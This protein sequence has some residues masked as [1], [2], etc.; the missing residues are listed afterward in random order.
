MT[1]QGTPK[2]V[3]ATVLLAGSMVGAS[4]ASADQF[5]WFG[6]TADGNWLLG[7]K[8]ESVG[9]GRRGYDD[10]ANFGIIFGYEFSRPIGL[11]GTSSIEFE[12]TDSFDNGD[13]ADDSLFGIGGD[14]QSENIAMFFTYRTP[15]NVYFKGKLGVLRSD[16]RTN[17]DGLEPETEQDT[18]FSYGAGL[19]LKLGQTGNFNLELEFVGSSGDNDLNM[20]SVGGIYKFR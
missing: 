3:L 19:G 7:A 6:E 16:L 15:G 14:W 13:V 9:S 2:T 5:T 20:I 1:F 18:S 8:V 17:L 10:A 4:T 11:E 12:Y